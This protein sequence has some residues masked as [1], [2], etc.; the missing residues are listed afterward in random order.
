M[1]ARDDKA[2]AVALALLQPR[3]QEPAPSPPPRR[4]TEELH[5]DYRRTLGFVRWYEGLLRAHGAAAGALAE[6]NLPAD[7]DGPL[8]RVLADAHRALL[9]HP[10]AAKAAHAA[11]AAEG[12]RFAA[13][14]EGARLK[15][16]LTRSRE[17]QRAALLWRALTMGMLGDDDE[18]V[19]PSTWLDNLMCAA[20]R[21]DLE[22]LLA[23]LGLARP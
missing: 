22:R 13:T 7:A 10:I 4:E 17:V 5:I 9:Q 14:D 16:R 11:L 20:G 3:P 1:N 21:H 19:L 18:A 23:R 8:L 2:R 15:E 12:R 6:T